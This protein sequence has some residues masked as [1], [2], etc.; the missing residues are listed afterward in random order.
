MRQLDNKQ[1]HE[2][3]FFGWC[4]GKSGRKCEVRSNSVRGGV[5]KFL[6][7]RPE[8][9]IAYTFWPKLAKAWN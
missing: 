5:M 9:L 3:L 6:E 7:W 8:E 2:S 4:W 1:Q